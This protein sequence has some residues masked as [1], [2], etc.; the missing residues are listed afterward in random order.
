MKVLL[1]AAAAA[2]SL[3]ACHPAQVAHQPGERCSV[4]QRGATAPSTTHGARL[5][6]TTTY[7]DRTLRWR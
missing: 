7:T 3:T 1:V 5:T 4:S 6:C 2:L